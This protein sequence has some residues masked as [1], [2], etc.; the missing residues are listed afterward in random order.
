MLQIFLDNREVIIKE[1]TSVKLNIENPLFDTGD[2]YTFDIELPLKIKENRDFFGYLDRID[3][4]KDAK[5]YS[6]RLCSNNTTLMSGEAIVTQITDTSVKVQLLGC[7][8]AYNYT[9]NSSDNYI[10]ELDLGFF[11]VDA[12]NTES[13]N[14]YGAAKVYLPISFIKNPMPAAV[15]RAQGWVMF[16]IWNQDAGLI[17]NG[18]SVYPV[19]TGYQCYFC[20][21]GNMDMEI[22]FA[23]AGLAVSPMPMLWFMAKKIAAATGKTL[24]DED[25][26]LLNNDFLSRIFIANNS[27]FNQWNKALPHWTVTQWW[28]ELEKAFG[29]VQV[30]VGDSV[31]LLSRTEYYTDDTNRTYID[32][33]VDEF[34]VDFNSEDKTDSSVN[35]VGFADHDSDPAKLLSEDVTNSA[36]FE[37]S[38]ENLD[39]IRSHYNTQLNKPAW[40]NGIRD[41]I[42]RCQDGHHYIYFPEY[43][44]WGGA[45]LAKSTVPAFVEVNQFRSRI[46]DS[47]KD[48]EVELRFVPCK[49]VDFVPAVV[50]ETPGSAERPP[51]YVAE[52]KIFGNI[53]VLSCPGDDSIVKTLPYRFSQIYNETEDIIL[54]N[55]IK[56]EDDA[57]TWQEPYTS[58]ICYLGLVGDASVAPLQFINNGTRY[59]VT[60]PQPLEQ[61]PNLLNL[62]NMT[63]IN[64][65]PN[66]SFTLNKFNG[67]DNIDS[68]TAAGI[69]INTKIKHCIRFIS[70][71]VPDCSD[72]FI[73]R[74]KKFVC[75]KLEVD[76][77][78]DGLRKYMTGYFY[79]LSS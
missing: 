10:D 24:A 5:T 42:F 52:D 19:G 73:I 56:G 45:D 8:A 3:A 26:C 36:R 13:V 1:G 57:A 77:N 15:N 20:R 40:L 61:L 27:G 28:E 4:P 43:D 79:S 58:D 70:D 32:K 76:I 2:K 31:K 53:R 66:Y 41:T 64:R 67:V 30:T 60:Y 29:V 54:A 37:D 9:S 18:W 44:T 47:K 11:S 68:S 21:P 63:Q 55:I 6:V 59:S 34:S 35:N 48:I 69:T 14:G 12:W 65:F 38:F 23:G 72:I 62:S 39:A 46:T 17:M 71:T 74:G 75:A 51:K 25:N 78:S 49:L 22:D 16:P 33:V 7:G 50:S